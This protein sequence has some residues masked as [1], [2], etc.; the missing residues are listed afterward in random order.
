MSCEA[1]RARPEGRGEM[2]CGGPAGAQH[3]AGRG[4]ARAPTRPPLRPRSEPMF[5]VRRPGAALAVPTRK[6]PIPGQDANR[7]NRMRTF[8]H[9]RAPLFHPP[10]NPVHP[11]L[12][13]P[14]HWPGPASAFISC[15]VQL[16]TAI[17]KGRNQDLN[18]VC[19][20]DFPF[21]PPPRYPIRSL[22]LL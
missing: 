22:A 17:G 15:V 5:G 1:D 12:R 11:V 10:V 14:T 7:M 9:G 3:P 21:F 13:C 8:N 20:F 4:R 2:T 16:R 6:T 18:L 19:G